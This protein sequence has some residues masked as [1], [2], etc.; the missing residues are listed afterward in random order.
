MAKLNAKP[1]LCRQCAGRALN[2]IGVLRYVPLDMLS[3]PTVLNPQL[4]YLMF[5]WWS[6]GSDIFEDANNS[7][8]C[9]VKF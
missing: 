6:F 9:C 4:S 1:N 3:D 2:R 8:Y 5:R 7:L